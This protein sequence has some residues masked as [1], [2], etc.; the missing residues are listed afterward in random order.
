MKVGRRKIIVDGE[1]EV[2]LERVS[3]RENTER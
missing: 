1:G 3:L 2:L